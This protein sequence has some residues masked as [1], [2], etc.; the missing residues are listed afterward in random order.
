MLENEQQVEGLY[1][2][3]SSDLT[4]TVQGSD[5]EKKE[6]AASPSA[7]DASYRQFVAHWVTS[8]GGIQL[9]T[10]KV[11]REGIFPIAEGDLKEAQQRDQQNAEKAFGALEKEYMKSKKK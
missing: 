11:V 4:I 5:V 8:E 6:Y 2:H 7:D 1:F 9:K 3:E 10:E